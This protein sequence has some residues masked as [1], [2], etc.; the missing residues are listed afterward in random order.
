MKLIKP[1]KLNIGDK[2]AIV[3]LSSGILGES[4]SKHQ[5]EIGVTR[6][7][8]EMVYSCIYAKYFKRS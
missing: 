8:R 7:I 5:L 6:L 4:S 1:K 2:V 3:S